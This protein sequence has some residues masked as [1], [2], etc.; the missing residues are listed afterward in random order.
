MEFKVKMLENELWWGGSAYH[1]AKMPYD[2]KTELCGD[3]RKLALNQTMPLYMSNRGRVIWS[4]S[5]FAYEIKNGEF[6]LEG[7][8]EFC[9]EQFGTTLREA[10]TGARAKFFPLKKRRLNR[11]FFKTVQYN[12]WIEC[13]YNQT[14]EH[15]LR[16]AHA[17]IDNGFEPGILMIDEGWH[18]RYGQW[19]FD[20]LKFPDPK[21]M[22]DEL[23][24]LGF[25]V[26]LWIVPNVCPDGEFFI[27]LYERN[28]SLYK[29]NP[30]ACIFVGDKNQ[31]YRPALFAWWNGFSAMLDFSRESDREFL[32]SQLQHLMTEYGIDGF[33]FDGGSL[34]RYA[35]SVT[36]EISSDLTPAQLNM[37]WNKFAQ[38]YDYHEYKDTYC[39]A[40]YP[41]IQRLSDRHHSW[42]EVDR[43]AKQIDLG[44]ASIIPCSIAE[45]IIGHPFICPD[46]V[47]GGEWKCFLPG[48]SV[49][50][51][52]FVR[53]AQLSALFPMMQYSKAP[54]DVLGEEDCRL[55][56]EAGKLHKD[57]THEIME[58]V[59]RAEETGE[60][61]L[62]S[63]EYNYPNQNYGYIVDEFMLEDKYL[64]APV[65]EKGARERRVILPEGEWLADDGRVYGK[66]E[67]VISAPLD[68]LIYFKKK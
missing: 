36:G 40:Q 62:R 61:I 51:E 4:D 29:D 20:R 1:G 67:Y 42:G 15:I 8:G 23:H 52:L 28:I 32:D 6:V 7:E 46:M 64:V 2:A 49:D 17:I 37:E 38:Q 9:L 56:I 33:K 65:I 13:L 68:R 44:L 53:W 66:G 39:G 12:T 11:D 21:A 34:S 16:Y 22:V 54:W 63:L 31:P 3:F 18:G 27:K 14:Q 5:P 58:M 45:G 24:S 60:P 25:K 43:D 50:S 41:T 57:F 10:H 59:T 26:M 48:M 19:E 35:S 55:V 47:G 30:D